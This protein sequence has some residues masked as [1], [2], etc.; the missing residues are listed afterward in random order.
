MHDADPLRS[1]ALGESSRRPDYR[2]RRSAA[3]PGRLFAFDDRA[4]SIRPAPRAVARRGA[5]HVIDERHAGQSRRQRAD[6][7]RAHRMA[8]DQPIS[9]AADDP[10]DLPR[11]PEVELAPHPHV[12]KRRMPAI[13]ASRRTGRASRRR[14]RPRSRISADSRASKS[15]TR[16]APA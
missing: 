8:V 7:R 10:G 1:D 16:S 11:R 6:H 15:C 9:F 3:R 14:N 5:M 2:K 4:E 13:A 12:V